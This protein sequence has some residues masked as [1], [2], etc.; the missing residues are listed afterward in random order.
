MGGANEKE[1]KRGSAL[2]AKVKKKKRLS[3]GGHARSCRLHYDLCKA[4]CYIYDEDQIFLQKDLHSPKFGAR[5][6]KET[7]PKVSY[8][9]SNVACAAQRVRAAA[10]SLSLTCVV[11]SS[12]V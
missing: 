4:L 1:Q 11:A 2:A 6:P 12:L 7:W 5:E 8:G 3:V 9:C 10:L